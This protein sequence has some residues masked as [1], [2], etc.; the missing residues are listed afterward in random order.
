MFK[1]VKSVAAISLAFGLAFAA[2][3]ENGSEIVINS[4]GLRTVTVA[5]G[6]LDLT[7][8]AGQETLSSRVKA[9]VRKVCGANN[10]RPTASQIQDYRTCTTHASQSALASLDKETRTRVAANF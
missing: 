5:Y 6:D 4:Q 1:F 10:G 2:N 8:A 3:A 9:A 7:T